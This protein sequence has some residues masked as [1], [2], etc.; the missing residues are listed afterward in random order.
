MKLKVMI[1]GANGLVGHGVL[2]KCLESEDIGEVLL[3][4]RWS[5][6]IKHTKLTELVV[7]DLLDLDAH[8]HLLI[9]YH[10]CFYCSRVVPAEIDDESYSQFAMDT[11]LGFATQMLV[12]N[13]NIVFCFLSRSKGEGKISEDAKITCMIEAALSKLIFRRLFF[14]RTN[15]VAPL[16]SQKNINFSQ[17]LLALAYPLLKFLMPNKINT[18]SEVGLAMI[19]TLVTDCERQ[20]LGAREIRALAS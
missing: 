16:T 13:P 8:E 19:N 5:S 15:L 4:G 20:A 6:G 1:T 11:A 10:A 3:I 12:L 14:F 2:L 17:R 18:T 7:P 9:G